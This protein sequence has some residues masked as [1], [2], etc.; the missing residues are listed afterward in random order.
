MK[1]NELINITAEMEE[2]IKALMEHAHEI[3]MKYDLHHFEVNASDKGAEAT[4][5]DSHMMRGT[6]DVG[7]FTHDI[8]LNSD[9]FRTLFVTEK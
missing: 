1:T 7:F 8:S 2:D 3:G 9:G 4:I 6:T 5:F